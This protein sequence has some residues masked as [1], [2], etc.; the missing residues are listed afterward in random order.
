MGIMTA[1]RGGLRIWERFQN[2]PMILHRS[3]ALS[4]CEEY[5]E[6]EVIVVVSRDMIARP[7]RET[8]T[9]RRQRSK[10]TT[11]PTFTLPLC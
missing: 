11:Y 5:R 8:F 1:I 3:Y 6:G 4:E 9:Q 7:S 2:A 10:A